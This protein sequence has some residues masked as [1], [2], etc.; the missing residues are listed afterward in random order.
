LALSIVPKL[1]NMKDPRRQ[2]IVDKINNQHQGSYV[3]IVVDP[4]A[5]VDEEN[6]HTGTLAIPIDPSMRWM[7]A[8]GD[9]FADKLFMDPNTGR[10]KYDPM[11]AAKVAQ[12]MLD[13][14]VPVDTNL[15]RGGPT[16]FT[17]FARM[18]PNANWG[19]KQETTASPFA[20]RV[21]E[22]LDDR[23]KPL[24]MRGPD[25]ALVENAVRFLPQVSMLVPP[26]PE[27]NERDRINA[28]KPKGYT[29]SAWG[30]IGAILQSLP[31]DLQRDLGSAPQDWS[32]DNRFDERQKRRQELM[33]R[34][35][36]ALPDTPRTGR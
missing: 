26:G 25:A 11:T 2:A 3:S 31:H 30:K 1:Y 23:L 24:G 8:L 21:S 17:R 13:A 36:V 4:T 9:Y 33:R 32:R 5:P 10:R 19:R 28:R 20:K 34:F 14:F 22:A 12:T 7:K 29:Q 35:G 27:V 16:P 18:S 6:R 15:G